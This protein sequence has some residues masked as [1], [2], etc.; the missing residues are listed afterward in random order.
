MATGSNLTLSDATKVERVKFRL[1]IATCYLAINCNG[2]GTC[3]RDRIL[4]TTHRVIQKADP[5]FFLVEVCGTTT[6]CIAVEIMQ[7][8]W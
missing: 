6:V 5:C 1:F 8:I 2:M 7:N 3:D 4:Q